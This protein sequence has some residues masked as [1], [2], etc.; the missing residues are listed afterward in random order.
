MEEVEDEEKA[1]VKG[2][3]RNE[4]NGEEQRKEEEKEQEQGRGERER[5]GG[6]LGGGGREVGIGRRKKR[7]DG[8]HYS[9]L[10]QSINKEVSL[11]L[12]LT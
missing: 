1:E 2:G 7:R 10:Q 8:T 3:M 4:S 5:E 12:K 6:G 9:W 11:R